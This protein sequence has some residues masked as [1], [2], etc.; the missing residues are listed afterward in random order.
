[1][2]RAVTPHDSYP[3]F[4]QAPSKLPIALAHYRSPVRLPVEGDKD[5]V[6]F[7]REGLRS[8]EQ[9]HLGFT[10]LEIQIPNAGSVLSGRKVRLV[11]AT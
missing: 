2:V 1:M 8:A 5:A 6:H 10:V 11:I 9:L 4:H 7:L 3:R